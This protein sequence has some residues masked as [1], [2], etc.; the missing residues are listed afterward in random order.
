MSSCS[1]DACRDIRGPRLAAPEAEV[2]GSEP[3]KRLFAGPPEL[4]PGVS[5]QVQHAS[6]AFS[7]TP[8][9]I[10]TTLDEGT[11]MPQSLI[12][13]G[14]VKTFGDI[15]LIVLSRGLDL[16][17]DWQ[18]MQRELLHLSSHSQQ[19]IADKSGHNIQLDQPDAAA[20][21]IT[22]MVAQLRQP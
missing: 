10:Q 5:P 18:A 7:V 11:G 13:A 21:A 17:Q 16:D 3:Q 20:T 8:R 15:P 6:T 12:Q 19:L 1:K 4:A 2:S 22:K 14:A 9:S